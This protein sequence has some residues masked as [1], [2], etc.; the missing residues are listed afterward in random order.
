MR[1]ILVALAASTAL[2]VTL[3][4]AA[5][6]RSHEDGDRASPRAHQD[7]D[8]DEDGD[9]ANGR[10]HNRKSHEGKHEENE[11]RELSA[12]P[13]EFDPDG[14]GIVAA[15]W[16]RHLGLPEPE[17]GTNRFGLLL[18]KNGPTTTN[19]SAGAVIHGVK[20]ITLTEL[21]YDV[22][23]GGHCSGGAPRFNV[24]T[25]DEDGNEHTHFVGACDKATPMPT[26]DPGWKRFR[27][28][29]SN[30]AQT[31]PPIPATETV[32]SIAVL[33]DEGTDTGTDFSGLVVI[34]NIDIN[35]D[36]IGGPGGER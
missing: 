29:P 28:D 25:A 15:R 35:G 3:S 4:S 32:K 5:T 33:F 21:G 26:G 36:L 22:R 12:E 16:V 31:F 34:D 30:P 6:A 7:R 27:F 18:S 11:K 19:A 23:N 10:H 2:I 1:R 8:R 13:F 24:V 20:G 9:L 14:T 17:D